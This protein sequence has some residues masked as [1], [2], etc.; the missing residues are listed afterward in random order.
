MPLLDLTFGQEK[1]LMD[2][3]LRDNPE[4]MD[5]P[6]GYLAPLGDVIDHGDGSAS[7]FLLGIPGKESQP[8][9]S[10]KVYSHYH[11]LDLDEYL[12]NQ[13]H[14]LRVY[15]PDSVARLLRQLERQYGIVIPTS[16]VVAQALTR[17]DSG[18]VV[19]QLT[20]PAARSFVLS[21]TS[22][23]LQWQRPA[24]FS[25]QDAV[26]Q[27]TLNAYTAPVAVPNWTLVSSD[28]LLPATEVALND[29][30]WGLVADGVYDPVTL[31]ALAY[32]ASRQT[33]GQSD[34]TGSA[35]LSNTANVRKC[36]LVVP[37]RRVDLQ[38]VAASGGTG[39]VSVFYNAYR[40][41]AQPYFLADSETALRTLLTQTAVGGD[42]NASAAT[43]AQL[44]NTLL[45]TQYGTWVCGAT[46]GHLRNLWDSKLT[47]RSNASL[48]FDGKTYNSRA[49]WIP[50]ANY[51]V[52]TVGG[53]TIYY[54]ATT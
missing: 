2:Q 1:L 18:S 22:F 28:W 23:T 35:V 30:A 7:V 37:D 25:V 41:S 13:P 49:L 9:I 4:L 38:S 51:S 16:A 11:R 46:A 8:Q 31:N 6:Q 40:L 50:D 32:K 34:F 20:V 52:S 42:A 21:K 5:Y 43:V 3:I 45:G 10:G 33:N 48:T 17:A 19:V 26:L 27:T 14:H 53:I 12:K 24:Q 47:E 44:F 39:I 29:F 54:N 36:G 15:R